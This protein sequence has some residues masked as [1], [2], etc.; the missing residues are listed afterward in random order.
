LRK[1][2]AVAFVLIAGAAV[3]LWFGNR[4]NSWVLGGLIGGLASL[5]LSIPI[6]LALFSYFTHQ[7][8]EG[9]QYTPFSHKRLL[10][11]RP[12]PLRRE[13]DADY[14]EEEYASV[15]TEFS[16]V[17][18][19]PYT[20]LH[21]SRNSG[22]LD[23]EFGSRM[24]SQRQL[25]PPTSSRYATGN[26]SSRRLPAAYGGQSRKTTPPVRPA[27]NRG[28]EE[29]RGRKTP[30]GRAPYPSPS[31]HQQAVFRSRF[32]SQALH[33]ARLEAAQQYMEEDDPYAIE[34]FS[35]PNLS[36]PPRVRRGREPQTDHLL[37]DSFS[38]DIQRP[39]VRRAPY[40][41]DDDEVREEMSHYRESPSV[42]R[43]SR[44]ARGQK[45]KDRPQ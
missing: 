7:H 4:L 13:I 41:Y 27:N 25:P 38:E 9:R 35:D 37:P 3:I 11:L 29:Q 40:T 22:W 14:E 21:G 20:S 31:S 1:A 43:S 5:L 36:P 45:N 15:D 30:T 26:P 28:E 42:R 16:A 34:D 6:S 19:E 17:V 18:E 10:S 8:D 32:R 2:V 12:T 39:V 33:A 44:Y 24:P 23:E